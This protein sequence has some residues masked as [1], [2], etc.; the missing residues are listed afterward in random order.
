MQN[1][2]THA[3]TIKSQG[4]FYSPFSESKESCIDAR[5]VAAVAVSALTQ[6]GHEG[7]AYELT[8]PE[9]L[10]YDEMARELSAALG[11]EIK[12][13]EIPVEAARSAMTGAGMQAW[14]VDAL[15]ELYYFYKDGG[16]AHVTGH[17]RQITGQEP[18]TFAQFARDYRQVFE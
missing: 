18:I 3:A 17:V 4:V 10:S 14:L 7:K 5:D 8:G 12:Y 13:V 1:T 11:R 9:S 15:V 2:F 6:E 16:A